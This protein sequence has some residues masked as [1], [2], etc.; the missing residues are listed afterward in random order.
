MRAIPGLGQVLL[1]WDIGTLTYE[2]TDWLFEKTGV[3]DAM[4]AVGGELYDITHAEEKETGELVNVAVDAGS[5]TGSIVVN[6]VSYTV[7]STSNQMWI[8]ETEVSGN[9]VVAFNTTMYIA[10]SGHLYPTATVANAYAKIKTAFTWKKLWCYIEVNTIA[11]SNTTVKS[12]INGGA[13]NQLLTVAAGATGEFS[14][15]SNSDSVVADDTLAVQIAT[16]NTSGS[17]TTYG[18]STLGE[19]A[20]S[21][22]VS[23]MYRMLLGVGS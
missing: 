14:D 19:Y 18:C 5:G 4:T 13:G 22:V 6:Q 9:G 23:K 12:Y 8:T 10:V 17:L 2:L 1:L 11:T 16:P 20:S 21:V 15:A 7:T 3:K